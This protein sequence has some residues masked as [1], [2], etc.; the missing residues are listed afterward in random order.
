MSSIDP[1]EVAY[2]LRPASTR[3]LR[4]TLETVVLLAAIVAVTVLIFGKA[5]LALY[6][7]ALAAFACYLAGS[8]LVG[9]FDPLTELYHRL[10]TS[11]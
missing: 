1:V 9:L 3:P 8:R 5:I 6:G 11:I 10:K 4:E 2:I 7:I